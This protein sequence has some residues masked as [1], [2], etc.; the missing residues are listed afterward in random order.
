[1]FNTLYN[2]I[3]EWNRSTNNRKKLQ[4][5]YLLITILIFLSASVIS[6]V[7]TKLGKIY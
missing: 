2:A 4:H 6:L 5:S 1:M 7:N 3:L